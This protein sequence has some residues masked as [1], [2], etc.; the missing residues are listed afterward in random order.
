MGLFGRK[1]KGRRCSDC[2]HYVMIEGY[3][4]CAK[5]IPASVDVRMLSGSGL[6]RQ[7]PK[8]PEEMTCPDW[9]SK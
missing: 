3:G 2:K 9:T 4:Y 7:C 5:A 6:K 1:D 8:C